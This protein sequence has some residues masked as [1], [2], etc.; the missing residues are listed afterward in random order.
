MR[1]IAILCGIILCFI[2]L[3]AQEKGVKFQELTFQQALDKAKTENKLVFMDCYTSWCGPCKYML[4]TV[5]VLPEMGTF[6]NDQFIN[7]K[8]DMEKGEGPRLRGRFHVTAY[9]T[10]LIIRPDG[11]LQHRI[12]G[13]RKAEDFLECVKRGAKEETSQFYLDDLYRQ[14][15]LDNKQIASYRAALKDAKRNTELKQ[16]TGEEFKQLSDAERCLASY[17]YI[18]D[19][20]EIT[21]DD[22]RFAYLIAHKT[23]FDKQVGKEIV[24]KRIYDSYFQKLTTIKT[25]EAISGL[26]A[27]IKKQVASVD[28]EGKDEII[29]CLRYVEARDNHNIDVLLDIMEKELRNLPR[30]FLWQ[31]P[32]LDF[33]AKEGSRK[34]VDRYIALEN[35]MV[36]AM[37]N[38]SLKKAVKEA[39]VKYDS[40]Q[41]GD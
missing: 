5:F 15:K 3:N 41:N 12:V 10:F 38:E 8:Y 21:P 11:A 23:D 4:N 34:Q 7:V 24:E 9:P 19:Q 16:V 33:I 40:M 37:D 17:W 14:G 39:F 36:E 30:A 20:N 29:L 35:E 2:Q 22:E 28:F 32:F 27:L 18:Y 26:T 31:A 13:S 1:R 6:F 25:N